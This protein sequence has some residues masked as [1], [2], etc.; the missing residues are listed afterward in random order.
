MEDLVVVITIMSGIILLFPLGISIVRRTRYKIDD[1]VKATVDNESEGYMNETLATVIE[2][3]L[4][5]AKDPNGSRWIIK[6]DIKVDHYRP[7]HIGIRLKWGKFTKMDMLVLSTWRLVTPLEDIKIRTRYFQNFLDDYIKHIIVDFFTNYRV[8]IHTGEVGKAY[9]LAH[10]VYDPEVGDEHGN[11]GDV[12]RSYYCPCP[13]MYKHW[14]G[15]EMSK[16]NYKFALIEKYVKSFN[17]TS[18]YYERVKSATVAIP[19][20]EEIL[21]K[22]DEFTCRLYRKRKTEMDERN[23]EL[24]VELLTR[25]GQHEGFIHGLGLAVTD[26]KVIKWEVS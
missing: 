21:K 20:T 24:R 6:E 10:L 22:L 15:K 13:I 14:V 19:E 12:Y 9:E 3:Y 25:M 1:F 5:K 4:S 8:A 16:D 7:V 26:L 2:P 11:T 18:T 23:E 17:A